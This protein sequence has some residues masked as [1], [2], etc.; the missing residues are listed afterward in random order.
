MKSTK[1]RIQDPWYRQFTDITLKNYLPHEPKYRKVYNQ[2]SIG[3][4]NWQLKITV[5]ENL[6]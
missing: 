3:I 1:W 5:H 4:R 6:F 2:T